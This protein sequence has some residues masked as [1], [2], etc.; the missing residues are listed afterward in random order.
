MKNMNELLSDLSDQEEKRFL[1]EYKRK[2]VEIEVLIGHNQGY[3]RCLKDLA[4]LIK[5]YESELQGS[6]SSVDGDEIIEKIENSLKKSMEKMNL[7]NTSGENPDTIREK[8]EL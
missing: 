4:K 1:E 5:E 6:E 8:D 2:F 7:C 3:N